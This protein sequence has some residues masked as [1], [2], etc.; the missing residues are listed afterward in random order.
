MSFT[1]ELKGKELK[2]PSDNKKVIDIV[3]KKTREAVGNNFTLGDLQENYKKYY[4]NVLQGVCPTCFNENIKKEDNF[5][6][7]CGLEIDQLEVLENE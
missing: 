7:I 6:T 5:C 1:I 2:I 3:V 4:I